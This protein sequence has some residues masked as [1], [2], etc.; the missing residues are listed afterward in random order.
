MHRTAIPD[1][2]I[3]KFESMSTT[4]PEKMFIRHIFRSS[5]WPLA[6]APGWAPG[7]FTANYANIEL[8]STIFPLT[9]VTRNITGD[10]LNTS[11]EITPS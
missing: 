11:K 1:R 2:D 3:M 5:S 10:L 6:G 8:T 7:L 4:Q 9:G